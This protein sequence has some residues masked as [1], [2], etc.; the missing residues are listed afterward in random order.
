MVN[1]FFLHYAIETGRRGFRA[2]LSAPYGALLSGDY[3]E[4]EDL[5]SAVSNARYKLRRENRAYSER[6]SVI[7]VKVSHSDLDSIIRSIKG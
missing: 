7:A 3:I 2:F 6:S 5:N 1:A 4:A